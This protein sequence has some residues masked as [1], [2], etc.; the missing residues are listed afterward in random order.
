MSPLAGR[1][2]GRDPIGCS[3]SEWAL[4]EFM[5][6]ASLF[7]LDYSGEIKGYNDDEPAGED[8]KSFPDFPPIPVDEWPRPVDEFEDGTEKCRCSLRGNRIR[9]SSPSTG[10]SPPE[11]GSP[12]VQC[13]LDE[14]VTV[15][16]E[17]TCIGEP[18]V[19]CWGPCPGTPCSQ[20]VCYRCVK[21]KGKVVPNTPY[22]HIRTEWG[23]CN[24]E[25]K[26]T[27]NTKCQRG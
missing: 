19:P 25:R 21:R 26:T 11:P 4:C 13:T 10:Q 18:D 2:L 23:K 6:S 20:Y 24:G 3:G 7:G 27:R 17:S 16:Y 8:P 1:F 5:E 14:E 22:P 12:L 9:P 15:R